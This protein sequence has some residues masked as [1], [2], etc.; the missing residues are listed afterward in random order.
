MN[1]TTHL[2]DDQE[3]QAENAV[4]LFHVFGYFVISKPTTTY[5]SNETCIYRMKPKNNALLNN[6]REEYSTNLILA[7]VTCVRYL[8]ATIAIANV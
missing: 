5:K 1:K 4:S 6:S 3:K 2:N 7:N 8:L